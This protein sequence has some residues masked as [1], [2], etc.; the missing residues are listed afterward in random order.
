MVIPITTS[1]SCRVQITLWLYQAYHFTP[2]WHHCGYTRNNVTSLFCCQHSGYTRNNY[3][4]F[5]KHQFYGTY[6]QMHFTRRISHYYNRGNR[7]NLVQKAKERSCAR[8]E[9]CQYPSTDE[10]YRE[11]Y[12]IDQR[13]L[14]QKQS[15]PDRR[16][17]LG[18]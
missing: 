18:L 5:I 17:G 9:N 3:Y 11:V 7:L 4:G 8:I 1:L 16:R 12:S 6:A 13:Q 10:V 2:C 14:F 15:P